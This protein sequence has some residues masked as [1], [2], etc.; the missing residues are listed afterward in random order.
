MKA[1]GFGGK[2]AAS[3]ILSGK[4]RVSRANAKKPA[5]LFNTDAGKFL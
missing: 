5:E 2:S 3:M 1:N 4:R